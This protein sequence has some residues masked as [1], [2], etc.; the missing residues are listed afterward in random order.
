MVLAVFA[1]LVLTPFWAL[2]HHVPLHYAPLAVALP[3]SN[4]RSLALMGQMFG[5]LC[6]LE[7]IAIL[8][9][10]AKACVVIDQA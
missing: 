1:L 8:A 5:A 9:G 3:A 7:Y 2:A 4:L 6:G 10:E